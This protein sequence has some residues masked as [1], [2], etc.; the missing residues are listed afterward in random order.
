MNL[1]V[2]VFYLFAAVVLISGAIVVLSKNVMKSAFNL[3]FTFFGVAGLYVLLLADF[4]AVT[5]IMVYIGGILVL[6]IFGV[7][8][9]TKL[10]G[11]DS[12]SGPIGKLNMIAGIVIALS[13]ATTLILTFVN[14]KWLTAPMMVESD[15]SINTIGYALMTDYILPFE[16]TSVLLLIALIGSALIAR[17]K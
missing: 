9:T 16:V 14:S 15:T 1:E 3:L 8:L 2:I 12:K 6:M 13:V 10:T 5:Q 7:M 4:V 11:V 17:R